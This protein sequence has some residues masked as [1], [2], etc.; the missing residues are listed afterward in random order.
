[1][2][3][4]RIIAIAAAIGI[5]SAAIAHTGATGIVKE[6]MVAMSAMGDAIKAVTPMMSGEADYDAAA[7]RE[8]AEA[9]GMHAGE[10]MT[11]LFPED[12][13]N[14][15]SYVKD[16]IWEDWETFAELA[17][18]LHTSSEGLALAAGNGLAGSQDGMTDAGAMMGGSDMMGGGMMADATMGREELAEMSAD[19]VFAMVSD[20]CSSC[21]TKFRKEAK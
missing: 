18:R 8:A 12:N 1:M 10:S 19:A 5:A 3:T 20:T 6:R 13:E 7:V 16:A 11:E 4:N 15:A 14:M 17:E 2:N 21:H 9:I